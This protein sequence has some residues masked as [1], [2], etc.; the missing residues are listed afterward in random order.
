VKKELRFSPDTVIGYTENLYR[1]I[2][3]WSFFVRNMDVSS[4]VNRTIV[5]HDYIFSVSTDKF[6]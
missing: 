4:S 6:R 1:S 5:S 3:L 2:G